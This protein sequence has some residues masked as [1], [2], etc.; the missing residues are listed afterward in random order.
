VGWAADTVG[1]ALADKAPEA[2]SRTVAAVG[3]V[4]RTAGADSVGNAESGSRRTLA[5]GS[6]GN[7]FDADS[8]GRT[9]D[10]DSVGRASD[11]DSADSTSDADWAGNAPGSGSRTAM[12]AG[13]AGNA[14]EMD[15]AAEGMVD[16]ASAGS[17]PESGSR[18]TAVVGSAAYN[19][20]ALDLRRVVLSTD[21]PLAGESEAFA[22]L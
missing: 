16:A 14:F 3:S 17:A 21:E 2:G 20:T 18:R 10:A 9:S 11:A 7:A 13:S 22:E 8:A 6:V 19:A 1:A 15:S 4:D 5:V 12:A